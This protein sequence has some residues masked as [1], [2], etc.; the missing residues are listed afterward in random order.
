MARDKTW[1][2]DADAMINAREIKKAAF[3][4]AM[5]RATGLDESIVQDIVDEANDLQD[6]DMQGVIV[7]MHRNHISGYRD[8]AS[9]LFDELSDTSG[10]KDLY[11]D[12]ALEFQK[13]GIDETMID[14]FDRL[15]GKMASL[16]SR[17]SAFKQ[18]AEATKTVITIERE[19][20]GL[21]PIDYDSSQKSLPEPEAVTSG[22]N[23]LHDKFKKVLDDKVVAT[24]PS[25]IVTKDVTPVGNEPNR[26]EE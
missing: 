21:K 18:L 8:L 17:I 10:A 26:V 15:M 1:V 13:S 11:R 4:K 25:D 16:G 14:K 2:R 5:S 22:L 9:Q 12:M 3:R 20:F 6:H 24:V 7:H 19:A 23:S